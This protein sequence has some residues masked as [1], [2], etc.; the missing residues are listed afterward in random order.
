MAIEW[1]LI[2]MQT[3][4]S[5]WSVQ[6]GPWSLPP[7][8]WIPVTAVVGAATLRVRSRLLRKPGSGGGVETGADDSASADG[9]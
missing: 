2:P 4:G 7:A 6:L 1:L 9:T 5:G 3:A 8:A